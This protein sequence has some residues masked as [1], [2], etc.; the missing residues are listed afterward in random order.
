MVMREKYVDHKKEDLSMEDDVYKENILDHYKNPRHKKVSTR[1]TFQHHEV[2]PI[3]GDML[4]F[5][6]E[7]ANGV[8]KDISF[9]GHGCA[10]SQA[11]ASMLADYLQGKRI[12]ALR[13]LKVEKIY[14]LLGIK[15]SP[16]RVKCAL[17]SFATVTKAY[18][19]YV[20]A[21]KNKSK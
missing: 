17:L 8:I 3:C 11:S 7:I 19:N 21:V 16:G 9:S 4:T 5:Y 12:E 15:I 1:C 10:I 18:E 20:G 6:V 13:E 14:E 2:N